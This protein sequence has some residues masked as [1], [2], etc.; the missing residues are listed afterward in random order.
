MK[1]G[2]TFGEVMHYFIVGG[3]ETGFQASAG[4]VRVIGDKRK[5]KHEIT[6]GT[7]RL[8]VTAYRTGTAAGGNGPTGFLPPGKYR[9][10]AFTDAFLEKHGAVPGS[11]IV[12]TE[13]GYMTEDAWVEMAPSMARGIRSLPVIRDAPGHWWVGK[14]IDGFGPHTSSIKAMEIKRERPDKAAEGGRRHFP[15]MPGVRSRSGSLR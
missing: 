15:R 8:S 7:S 9:N 2:R 12:M 1:D 10:G 11:T 4:D 14:I 6:T 5:A 13:N 3:D